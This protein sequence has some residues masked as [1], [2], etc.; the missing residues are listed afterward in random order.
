MVQLYRGAASHLQGILH[1]LTPA[2]A[3]G[4]C[5][6]QAG[7]ALERPLTLAPSREAAAMDSYTQQLLQAAGGASGSA[8]GGDGASGASDEVGRAAG[9]LVG[10]PDQSADRPHQITQVCI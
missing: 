6:S 3:C 4:N 1:Q 7:R 2:V 8:G 9:E 10:L 5:L